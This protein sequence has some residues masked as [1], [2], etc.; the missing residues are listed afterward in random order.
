MCPVDEKAPNIIMGVRRKKY[1]L[2]I[3]NPT[4]IEEL[5]KRGILPVGYPKG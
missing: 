5:F 1:T 3:L 2:D 4:P